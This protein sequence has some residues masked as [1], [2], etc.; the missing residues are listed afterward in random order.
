MYT[1]MCVLVC[2][3]VLS[4]LQCLG[5]IMGVYNWLVKKKEGHSATLNLIK[6]RWSQVP[7][8][9]TDSCTH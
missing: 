3:A 9:L 2:I 8:I 7:E 6:L 4:I 5:V 1:Y